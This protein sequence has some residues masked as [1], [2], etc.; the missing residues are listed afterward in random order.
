MRKQYIILFILLLILSAC[1]K[2]EKSI[3]NAQEVNNEKIEVPDAG[4]KE[5]VIQDGEDFSV[6]EADFTDTMDGYQMKIAD[7]YTLETDFLDDGKVTYT[8]FKL[9]PK[10][11]GQ[12][13]YWA[14]IEKDT[15]IDSPKINSLK[16]FENMSS[17]IVEANVT[18]YPTLYPSNTLF[19]FW[20]QYRPEM[21]S[22]NFHLIHKI[23]GSQKFEIIMRAPTEKDPTIV[24]TML[25]M[26]GTL[27]TESGDIEPS[28][29]IQQ[30]EEKEF[31]EEF[32]NI[33]MPGGM[34]YAGGRFHDRD[35]SPYSGQ[36]EYLGLDSE[37]KIDDVIASRI[38]SQEDPYQQLNE[39]PVEIKEV[40]PII[41]R[42]ESSPG[43]F[44]MDYIFFKRDEHW[45]AV[46][47]MD[48]GVYDWNWRN[49]YYSM[50]KSLE[51][52]GTK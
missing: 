43:G 4:E 28:T 16:L 51:M 36:L 31:K 23:I 29:Q 46:W 50:I 34:E 38:A 44:F 52:N 9:E 22:L 49:G 41:F 1:G 10:E 14:T 8:L 27:Q 21:G 13:A 6:I 3:S 20:G 45:F 40:E 30:I 12:P 39:I 18:D 42:Y 32:Y 37:I 25:S 2:G 11:N 33:T 26:I 47:V 24:A 19:Y 7:G 15:G 35:Y 17:S 48:N 5:L